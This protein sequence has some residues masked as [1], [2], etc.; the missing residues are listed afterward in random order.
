LAER[1]EKTYISI[2]EFI[3]SWEKE[4]YELTHL[5]Y[6][7]FL[8]INHLGN[9]IEHYFQKN[10]SLSTYLHVESEDIG[11]LAFNIGDSLE[12]FLENNCFGDCNLDCP[13][14]LNEKIYPDDVD[15][16]NHHFH[17]LQ[18]AKTNELNKKQFL[19]TDI[20]NYVVLDTLF[21]FYNYE[22]E[23]DID[24]SDI[25]LMQFAD[26]ITSIMESFIE[27]KGQPFLKTP[28]ESAIDLF[29]KLVADAEQDWDDLLQ[30]QTEEEPD[31]ADDWK[32]GELN[33]N[34]LIGDYENQINV[35]KS[36]K[37]NDIKILGYFNNYLKDYAGIDRVDEITF[38]DLEEFYTFWLIRE[39]LLEK[40]L[41]PAAINDTLMRF[42]KWLDL[43]KE[44][45]LSHLFSDILRTHANEFSDALMA[46][47][48]YFEKNSLIDGVLAS[49]A[50][51]NNVISG[52][53]YIDEISQNSLYRLRDVFLNNTYTNVQI[54]LA[55]HA[56]SISGMIIDAA[57]KPTAYGWRLINLEYIFP[58][59]AR[60]YLH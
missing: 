34:R 39:S 38:E 57:I 25:G 56:D 4:I 37:E 30:S 8:L 59:G 33:I 50:P 22:M 54:N 23:L 5:D 26:F 40:E 21:D 14:K 36:K 19:L 52:L 47:R 45:N 24:D 48:S 20:L 12:S 13:T 31:E 27:T 15:F 29:E 18:F 11:T 1:S 43:S 3:S 10:K 16:D 2:H 58:R 35:A 46:I 7:A 44:I 49:N 32:I 28:R 17:V 9:Q 53:F 55:D 41:T 51:E 60:A 42:F 6:F